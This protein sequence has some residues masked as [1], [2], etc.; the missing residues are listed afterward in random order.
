MRRGLVVTVLASAGAL[1]V[2]CGAFSSDDDPT[3]ASDAGVDAAGGDV[4]APSDGGAGDAEAGTACVPEPEWATPDGGVPVVADCAGLKNVPLLSS[5]EHCGRCDHSCGAKDCKDGVC[6]AEDVDS[7]SQGPLVPVVARGGALYYYTYD[8]L[9]RYTPGVGPSA[10]T[11]PL[12]SQIY[13]ATYDDALGEALLQT[14]SDLL[15][16]PLLDAGAPQVLYS[17]QHGSA[18][19]LAGAGVVTFSGIDRYVGIPTDGG[20]P[21][22]AFS[23]VSSVPNAATTVPGGVAVLA[24]GW[25]GG[26]GDA[27]STVYSA[28]WRGKSLQQIATGSNL[29][30]LAADDT[31]VYT[32]QATG[33]GRGVYRAPLTPGSEGL[34]QFAVEPGFTGSTLFPMR[35]LAVDATHVYWS[36][37]AGGG[38]NYAEIVKKAKCGGAVAVIARGLYYPSGMVAMGDSLYLGTGTNRLARVAK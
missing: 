20:G 23:I 22:A 36:R 10:V 25:T 15:R 26:G 16:V 6:D 19:V 34:T 12:A 3:P 2:A 1:A 8:V 33:D 32:L 7:A 28:T 17:T 24:G 30:T 13:G 35:A 29:F 27:G 9:K 4:A 11:T 5:R 38:S 21:D 37:P 14:Y 18:P 31:H